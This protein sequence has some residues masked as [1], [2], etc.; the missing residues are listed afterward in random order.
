[1]GKWLHELSSFEVQCTKIGDLVNQQCCKDA[2]V[3]SLHSRNPSLLLIAQPK[4]LD[5]AFEEVRVLY[6][7]KLVEFDML[8]CNLSRMISKFWAAKI[9]LARDDGLAKIADQRKRIEKAEEKRLG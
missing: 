9:A 2:K 8:D 7:E 4:V 1:M 5:C 3:R 6:S